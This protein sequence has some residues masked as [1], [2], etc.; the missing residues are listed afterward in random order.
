MTERG[1][2]LAALSSITWWMTPQR[3]SKHVCVLC[4]P[5][6]RW[7]Q[8]LLRSL[9]AEGLV[10]DRVVNLL[11]LEMYEIYLSSSG[12]WAA[13]GIWQRAMGGRFACVHRRGLGTRA[14]LSPTPQISLGVGRQYGYT[15]MV[16][17]SHS[18]SDSSKSNTQAPRVR[19]DKSPLSCV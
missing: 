10:S 14:R 1:Q 7:I 6:A 17:G 19:C 18:V 8:L 2:E 16:S 12:R 9:P 15:V 11:S 3:R 13:I 4:L 5:V